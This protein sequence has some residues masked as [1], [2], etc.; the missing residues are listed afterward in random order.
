MPL[1]F[2][3]LATDGTR[4][5][6]VAGADGPNGPIFERD[7]ELSDA[8]DV[9]RLGRRGDLELPLPFAAISGVHARLLRTDGAWVV[10]DAGSINGTWLDG[11]RL[12]PG[13]RR[14]L[15]PGAELRLARVR[16]RF[17]GTGPSTAA[18]G[19]TATIARQLVDDL[20][21][22]A[23]P[24]VRVARGAPARVLAVAVPGLAYVVGRSET[25]ALCLPTSEVSREHAA[26]ERDPERVIVRDLG[27]KNGVLVGG[28]RVVREHALVDGDLIQIGPVSLTFEDPVTRYLRELE[29]MP[30]EPVAA[31]DTA[32]ATESP[33]A[34]ERPAEPAEPREP[35]LKAVAP[36]PRGRRSTQLIGWVAL[37][38]LVLLAIA[39]VALWF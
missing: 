20:F 34:P 39:A 27:S 38:V 24:T 7:V 1:R 8:L 2:R 33:A 3:V 32:R 28:V 9:L 31:R 22:D 23:A 25:C 11:A 12:A 36:A 30:P 16:L 18:A 6:G 17:E 37:T 4:P 13:A 29:R 10:E 19:G 14:P 35:K 26:F 5:A 15:K 21:A